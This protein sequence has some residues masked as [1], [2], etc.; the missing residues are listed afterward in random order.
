[1]GRGEEL[2]DLFDRYARRLHA[3]L[4]SPVVAVTLL[5][6]TR[7]WLVGAAGLAS[8]YQRCR[9]IPLSHTFS[10]YVV[11]DSRPLVVSDARRVPEL[12]G[13]PVVPDLNVVAYAGWPISRP[14][15][16]VA[17]DVPGKLCSEILGVV[18]AIDHEPREWTSSDLLTL[19]D[20]AHACAD[21]LER[22]V[23]TACG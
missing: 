11:T 17:G 20:V 14:V 22:Y 12:L 3:S 21:D 23:V 2:D 5:E 13:H 19:C 10:Q 8:P 16:A 6:P 9:K 7:R 18:C 4:G 15:A 1:V